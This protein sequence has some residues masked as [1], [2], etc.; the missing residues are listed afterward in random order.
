MRELA[1]MKTR[2]VEWRSVAEPRLHGPLEALV[3]PVIASRCDGDNLPIFNHVSTGLRAGIAL[4][5]FDPILPDVLGAS[6]YG[7]PFAIGHE[8]IAQVMECGEN[9]QHIRKGQLVIV[10]WSISCGSC[11]TCHGGHTS[12]C[13]EAGE[14][15]LSGYGFGAS[16]GP[17]GGMVSDLLRVPFADAM[18]VPVPGDI[19]PL[20]LAS[21][22]DNMPDA[23]R[24]VGPVL[25]AH[26]GAPILV[27]GGGAR[28]I[29][30]YAAGMAVALG[31]SRVDYVDYDPERLRI[32]EMLGARVI[33][34]KRGSAW[35]DRHAPRVR[36]PYLAAVE[37]SST[38]A[39]LRYALRSLSTGG[40]CTAVGFYFAKKTGLPL[41][42]M[43][44]SS[45]T[46][47]VGLSHPRRDIPSVIELVR[48]G[49]F[50]PLKVATL[51]ADWED[52]PDAFMTRTTKV[53]IRR[54]EFKGVVSPT[55]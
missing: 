41:M 10:P 15:L 31:S 52:A 1:Y 19:D 14:T 48:G 21:A 50:D 51:V 3:R 39:G 38:A 26:P 47:H 40:R 30:L 5:Y 27:V 45:T 28:S 6:P 49:H 32:A 4:H 34:T 16:L 54:N 9:V 7:K 29:G 2:R 37:A 46:L 11:P 17:W 43:Y 55:V 12:H 33:E 42:Q 24:G 36:G 22:S 18:L 20:K 35:F 53:V 13:S 8:C 25:H 23:W 44:A